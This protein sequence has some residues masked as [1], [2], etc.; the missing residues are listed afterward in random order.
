MSLSVLLFFICH[1]VHARVRVPRLE[2]LCSK[3]WYQWGLDVCLSLRAPSNCQCRMEFSMWACPL[4]L[5]RGGNVPQPAMQR[6]A[7]VLCPLHGRSARPR[8]FALSEGSDC[9]P[10]LFGWEIF[11]VR[12]DVIDISREKKA[13]HGHFREV[14]SRASDKSTFGKVRQCD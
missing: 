13:Y 11:F 14:L 4:Y 7:R 12:A 10:E 1:S 9:S 3:S 6:G 8:A 2:T 5:S